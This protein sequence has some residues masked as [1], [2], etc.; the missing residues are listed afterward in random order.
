MP[1][2]QVSGMYHKDRRR[3]GKAVASLIA[4]HLVILT[5]I[6][7]CQ[8]DVSVN[9]IQEPETNRIIQ[10]SV[11]YIYAVIKDDGSIWT[12]GDN[13][14]GTLGNGTTQSSSIP[15]RV[16]N[17]ENA[18]SFDQF[19]GVA[20]ASDKNGFIWFWGDYMTYIEIPDTIVRIPA[21]ISKIEG[22]QT[23]SLFDMD[24]YILKNDHTIWYLKLDHTNPTKFIQPLQIS[25]INDAI[26]LSGFVVLKSDGTLHAL[27]RQLFQSTIDS[28]K[29]VKTFCSVYE[30]RCLII[31]ADSTV[32]AW[33]KNEFGQLGNGTLVDSDVP[34]KVKNL[35]GI[36]DV[37]AHYDYNLALKSDG[38]VWFWG[39][40]HKNDSV[41]YATSTPIRIENLDHVI[42]IYANCNCLVTK[43]DG[44][45]WIFNVVDK[46]SVR[47][48]FR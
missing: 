4:F 10:L 14:F 41:S 7:S 29:G 21:K 12:W 30:R 26:A 27:N 9:S 8:R 22:A 42:K 17:I 25:G 2:I 43:E 36:V 48:M 19:F 11:D 32:W 45:C 16:L 33:G 24:L 40:E 6:T 23:L 46:T 44:S 18:V 35:N 20:I 13:Y 28:V 38:S 5:F 39:F 47:V 37:S 3:F 34:V 31:R 15:V 1:F